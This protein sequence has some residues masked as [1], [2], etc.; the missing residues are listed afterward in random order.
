MG[1]IWWSEMELFQRL[2]QLHR[3]S[4]AQ[5]QQERKQWSA[6]RAGLHARVEALEAELAAARAAG[7]AYGDD[8]AELGHFEVEPF[9]I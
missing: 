8:G 9:V 3:R 1:K 7:G 4:D 2:L 6:E 5:L